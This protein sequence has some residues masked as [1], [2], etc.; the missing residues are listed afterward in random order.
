MCAVI[1]INLS[2]YTMS[3]QIEWPAGPFLLAAFPALNS[4]LD[5]GHNPVVH[6]LLCQIT[7]LA[8]LHKEAEALKRLFNHLPL[9]FSFLL[10]SL[11]PAMS[12]T[13]SLVEHDVNFFYNRIDQEFDI[14][15]V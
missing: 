2:V 8:S 10:S 12:L 6:S 14:I 5:I 9:S 1:C 3:V 13:H 11:W 4:S 15:R 7:R